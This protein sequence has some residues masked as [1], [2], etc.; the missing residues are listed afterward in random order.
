[1]L[2]MLCAGCLAFT[3]ISAV[4]TAFADEESGEE[5]A[6]WIWDEAGLIAYNELGEVCGISDRDYTGE[7]EILPEIYGMPVTAINEGAFSWCQNITGIKIPDSVSVIGSDA[8]LHCENLTDL[9]LP[10]DLTYIGV[11]A[12]FFCGGTSDITIPVK[13]KKIEAYA[14]F[15]GRITIL[16]PECII[17]DGAFVNPATEICGYDGSTAEAYAN[18]HGLQF[19]SLGACPFPFTPVTTAVTETTATVT[20]TTEPAS[21]QYE[22][23]KEGNLN[24]RVYPD[25]AV[26]VRSVVK[27]DEDIVIPSHVQNVPV[28]I[29]GNGYSSTFSGG[30]AFVYFKK[31]TI[32]DTVVSIEKGALEEC[33]GIEEL[34]LPASVKS[35]GAYACVNCYALKTVVL[36]ESVESIGNYAFAECSDLQSVTIMNPACRIADS[37][38]TFNHGGLVRPDQGYRGRILGYSGSTA[39]A[40]AKKYGYRFKALDQMGVIRYGDVNDD[41]SVDLKD[42]GFMRRALA[43]W[44][45]TLNETAA[46]INK[47]GSFDL[48]D[49]VI[50]RRYLAGG[51]EIELN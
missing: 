47:D 11:Q 9:T 35:I 1:M 3:G 26:L 40:Y 50:L 21:A 49:V 17:S 19:E 32:P 15:M 51:W 5:T 36:P 42:I 23:V 29:L 13:T 10:S 18:E 12:F 22:E 48:K 7:I 14:F 46:D 31:L 41:D 33:R 30:T 24:F 8:F 27:V 28:T 25:H 38:L 20:T 2:A 4:T 39:E 34:E 16:N 43:G 37:S 45:V 6:E 44:D